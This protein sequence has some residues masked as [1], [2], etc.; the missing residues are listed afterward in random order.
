MR[1]FSAYVCPQAGVCRTRP[2]RSIVCDIIVARMKSGLVIAIVLAGSAGMAAA[3]PSGEPDDTP[4]EHWVAGAQVEW[5]PAGSFVYSG[6]LGEI[7]FDVAQAYGGTAWVGYEMDG[8]FEFGLSARVIGNERPVDDTSSATELIVAPRLAFHA[9]P[10]G[11]LD[12]SFSLAPGYSHVFMP[13]TW[14]Y[15]DASGFTVDFGASAAYPL[16]G[17]RLYGMV[18]FG[19]QRGFQHTTETSLGPHPMQLDADF[20]TDYGHVSVGVVYRFW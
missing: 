7:D 6:T 5:M 17:T 15:P 14:A 19:Y 13:A 16:V 11:M 20:A 18:T 10:S 3:A 12:L 9:R 4:T 1:F 8:G 2:S